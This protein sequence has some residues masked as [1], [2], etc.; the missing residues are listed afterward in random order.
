MYV[1][2]SGGSGPASQALLNN[3]TSCGSSQIC[4]FSVRMKGG[5]SAP[6]PAGRE[7]TPLFAE[8]L[9]AAELN[10]LTHLGDGM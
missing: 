8:E 10:P 3:H 1:V 2:S 4:P 6:L 9:L 7:I 5:L